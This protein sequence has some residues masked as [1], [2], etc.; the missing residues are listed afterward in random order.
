MYVKCQSLSIKMEIKVRTLKISAAQGLLQYCSRRAFQCHDTVSGYSNVY[1]RSVYNT[2][3]MWTLLNADRVNVTKF[4]EFLIDADLTWILQLT[5]VKNKP[6]K[7]I[8]VLKNWKNCPAKSYIKAFLHYTIP[9][10]HLIYYAAV[11]TYRLRGQCDIKE[12]SQCRVDI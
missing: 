8:A 10:M 12:M 11:Y 5:S 4:L 9:C 3:C 6:F 2:G 1:T 7:N